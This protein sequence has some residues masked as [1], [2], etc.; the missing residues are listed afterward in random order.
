MLRSLLPAGEEGDI[1]WC[2]LVV[3]FDRI[4]GPHVEILKARGST[5]EIEQLGYESERLQATCA[6]YRV[7]G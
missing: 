4:T 1:A 2:G 6:G 5:P 3:I 7:A